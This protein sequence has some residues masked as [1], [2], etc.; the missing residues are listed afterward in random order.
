MGSN[1]GLLGGFLP[2]SNPALE[3]IAFGSLIFLLYQ[4]ISLSG[5]FV[6]IG[7]LEVVKPVGGANH[8]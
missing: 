2:S 4:A 3:P 7:V 8:V 6:G 5:G 1:V